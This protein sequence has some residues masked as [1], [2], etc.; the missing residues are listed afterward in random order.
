MLV[1]RS[2]GPPSFAGREAVGQVAMIGD[3]ECRVVGVVGNVR[4]SA[5][6]ERAPPRFI[7]TC[8]NGT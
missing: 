7:C 1:E 4:H 3:T 8:R 2:D 5:L 6:D